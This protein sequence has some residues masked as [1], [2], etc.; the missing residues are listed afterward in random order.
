ML[1]GR[2]SKL[3]SKYEVYNLILMKS[4]HKTFLDIAA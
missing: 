2:K 1:G 4:P 3:Q